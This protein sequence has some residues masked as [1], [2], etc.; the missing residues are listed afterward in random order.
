[1]SSFDIGVRVLDEFD[2]LISVHRLRRIAE[3]ALALGSAESEAGLS[4]VIADDDVVRDLN[5]RY[6]GL[7]EIT[8]VLSFSFSHEG[9]YYGDGE[10]WLQRGEKF[11]FV[12]PPGEK[13][14]LGEVVISYSQAQ[15]QAD[16]SGHTVDEELAVL[17]AHGV[18]HL[19]GHD[20]V[21]PEEEAAMKMLEK[22]VL[23]RVREGD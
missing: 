14:S 19:L 16:Q 11:G 15:R 9:E 8:D 4:V 17:L 21:A 6:R 12:L 23:A 3:N 5:N 7:D 1:M 2:G 13:D 18:L 20:H 10:L 22:R